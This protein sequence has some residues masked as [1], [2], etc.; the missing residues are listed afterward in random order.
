[1]TKGFTGV[2]HAVRSRKGERGATLILV[3]LVATFVLV[4]IVGLAI[5]GALLFWM[6]A[7]LSAAVDAAALAGGRSLNVGSN[8]S[9][10]EA[11]ATQVALQY[12]SANFPTGVMRSSIVGGTP[13]VVFTYPSTHIRTV[14]VTA[15]AIVPLFFMPILHFNTG[16]IGAVGTA[17]RRDANIILVLDRSSSMYG[18]HCTALIASAQSFVSHF[19][20]GRDRLALITFSSLASLDFKPSYTFDTDSPSLPATLAT[21]RCYGYTSTAEGLSL[22]Y[23][24]LKNLP[25]AT[26]GALNVILLFT[27]GSPS[28][29]IATFP[30]KTKLDTRYGTGNGRN[31]TTDY[32][33]L[34]PTPAS[35]CT[36]SAPSLLVDGSTE[37]ASTV[38]LMNATGPTE[39]LYQ[40]TGL[41]PLT[42]SSLL[43][44]LISQSGC[45]FSS[46]KTAP[47]EDIANIPTTDRNGNSTTGSVPGVPPVDLFTTNTYAPYNGLIRP[48]MPRTVRWVAFN[49]ADAQ[50]QKIHNDTNFAPVIYT[51]GLAG[52]ETM[53]MN[54][55]F[56]ERLANDPR[57]NN[58][59][60]TKPQGQF[61]LATDNASVAAAFNQ[62]ASQVLR[63][64]K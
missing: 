21:L 29:I 13:S 62:I 17:S 26:G 40:V 23:T 3:T 36:V 15:S 1:M 50:A 16:T 61:I 43:P 30:I 12:F 55:A 24:T 14:Q 59:D 20:N 28:S 58:Y 25:N 37:T 53:A 54:Q 19:A 4:P 64:S 6:N 5:D 27:D 63:L 11:N 8:Q 42:G 9:A 56:M 18:S 2:R 49:A 38:A 46:D 35:S 10:Q 32:T 34:T 22:A 52:N 48:D 57:A 51:I 45:A 31:G 60:Q 44:P 7:R 47:R 39:G 41:W 33:V